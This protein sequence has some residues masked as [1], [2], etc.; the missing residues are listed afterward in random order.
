MFGLR[1]RQVEHTGGIGSEEDTTRK[2]VVV[3]SVSQALQ[4]DCKLRAHQTEEQ[5]TGSR[6]ETRGV[7]PS[8]APRSRF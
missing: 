1:G 6:V 3:G 7:L 4:P 2:A 8:F 5:A